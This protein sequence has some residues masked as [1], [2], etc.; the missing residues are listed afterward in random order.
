MTP[1]PP[2]S[3][4]IGAISLFVLTLLS[5]V[6]LF[7]MPTGSSAS[8]SSAIAIKMLLFVIIKLPITVTTLLLCVFAY[9]RSNKARIALGIISLLT[10]L[11]TVWRL[12]RD[13]VS[14]DLWVVTTLVFVAL[15]C[16]AVLLLF[17]REAT[18]WFVQRDSK[19]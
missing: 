1:P 5:V 16:I 17:S 11:V 2:K 6:L 15:Q 3:V 19:Q 12:G 4:R 8:N 18:M 9:R 7:A 13:G 14:Y 10:F